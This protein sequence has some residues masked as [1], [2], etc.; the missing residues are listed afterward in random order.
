MCPSCASVV[1]HGPCPS[2]VG[3]Q[4]CRAVRSGLV[5]GR[6]RVHVLLWNDLVDVLEVAFCL[7]VWVARS[8]LVDLRLALDKVEAA[9]AVICR[10]R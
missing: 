1:V 5:I 2:P 3:Q 9:G 10:Q 6:L 8:L 7:A 4:K